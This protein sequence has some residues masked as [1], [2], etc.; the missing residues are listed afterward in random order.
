MSIIKGRQL[1][2]LG[3]KLPSCVKAVRGKKVQRCPKNLRHPV[4][5]LWVITWECGERNL[6]HLQDLISRHDKPFWTS[7]LKT[8]KC[9]PIHFLH[10]VRRMKIRVLLFLVFCAGSCYSQEEGQN[11]AKKQGR[12]LF[13][14]TTTSTTIMSTYALCWKAQS[15]A[16][17]ALYGCKRKRSFPLLDSLPSSDGNTAQLYPTKSLSEADVSIDEVY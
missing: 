8:E 5:N 7:Y 3:I 1:N 10:P 9:Y 4:R 16:Q 17:T 6:E 2:I 15:A 13:A 11:V 12:V 14:T